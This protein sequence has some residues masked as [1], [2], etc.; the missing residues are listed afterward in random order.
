MVAHLFKVIRALAARGKVIIVGRAGVCLTRQLPGGFH[1]RLVSPLP[2]RVRRVMAALSISDKEA[3]RAIL[4]RDRARASLV[5]NYFL[6]DIDD[7]LLYDMVWNT[8][9]IAPKAIAATTLRGVEAMLRQ[10]RTGVV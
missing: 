2:T 6:R 10:G 1:L 4:Q 8:E 7:P 5:K 9:T 3:R